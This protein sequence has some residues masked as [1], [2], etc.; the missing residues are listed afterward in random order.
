MPKLITFRDPFPQVGVAT[1]QRFFYLRSVIADPTVIDGDMVGLRILAIVEAEVVFHGSGGHER[2]S[3]LRWRPT[4]VTM[5]VAK[6]AIQ[7]SVEY[8]F[9]DWKNW[10]P[11]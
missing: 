9:D 3:T 2:R 6:S 8:Q 10:A 7:S 5:T 4:P 11:L 1:S